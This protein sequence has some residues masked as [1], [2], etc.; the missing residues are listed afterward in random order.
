MK[1]KQYLSEYRELNKEIDSMCSEKARLQRLAESIG[2]SLGGNDGGK[3]KQAGAARFESVI[4]KMIVLDNEINSKIDTM[5]DKRTEI[6]LTI[7]EIEDTTLR[8]LLRNK[9][10]N[11]Y[12]FERCAVEQNFCWRWVLALHGRALREVDKLINTAC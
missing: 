3:H 4:D 5:I 10:I 1:A 2:G 8:T 6:E 11:G 7:E 9:Y 12:T